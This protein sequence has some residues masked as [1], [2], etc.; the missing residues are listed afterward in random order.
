MYLCVLKDKCLSGIAACTNIRG[1]DQAIANYIIIYDVYIYLI[2][3]V[4]FKVNILPSCR[5]LLK[6]HFITAQKDWVEKQN[7]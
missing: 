1:I 6:I 7:L 4:L 5:S 2:N 3:T